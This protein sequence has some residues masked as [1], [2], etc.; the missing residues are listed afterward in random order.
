VRRFSAWILPSLVAASVATAD[1]PGQDIA[2][3][4]DQALRQDGH[5]LP[6]DWG[7][8][9]G[10]KAPA[11]YAL[12]LSNR[13]RIVAS[14]EL[15]RAFAAIP[16]VRLRIDPGE[17]F[18]AERG[19]YTH[20]TQTG[21]AWE[22]PVRIEYVRTNGLIATA[23]AGVRIQGGWSRRPIESPKHSFRIIFRSRYGLTRW[24]EP[25]FQG[26]VPGADQLVLRSGNNHS[27]LH[28][29][30][31][32]RTSA[33][34][35]RDPWMR[36]SHA[37]MGHPAARSHPVHVFLNDLYW[38][39]YDLCERPDAHFAARAWGGKDE[40]YDT[41]NADKVL[42][43]DDVAWKRLMTRVNAGVDS[44][45]AY[46][47]IQRELDVPAFIDY[48]LLN[49]FGANGDWDRGSNWYAARRRIP[50]GKWHVIVWDGER[51]LE[52]PEDDRL[53]DDDDEC[54]TR[55]FQRLRQWPAFRWEF[56]RRAHRHLDSGG[57]LDPDRAAERFKAL[58][59]RLRPVLPAESLR[60]GDYRHTVHPHES[61]PFETYTVSQHWEPEIQRIVGSYFPKRAAAFR[62]QLKQAGL[63]D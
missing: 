54:P 58:A 23:P 37:A 14:N 55:V 44:E 20:P 15:A 8:H 19:I 29:D 26:G 61:G 53:L 2:S 30:A 6:G 21:D 38:G 34:Y 10:W 49:L 40:D 57:A 56:S 9:E 48:M 24:R 42:S 60:W 3:R 39:V 43:G 4:V 18:D 13:D 12:S 7:I 41:R 16:H 31:R 32:E 11:T 28:R 45:A 25:L 33:D 59:D 5:G 52:N 17:L 1:S 27:W 46:E 51:V 36:A 35:V 50:T 62:Q 63:L 47:A 22:R